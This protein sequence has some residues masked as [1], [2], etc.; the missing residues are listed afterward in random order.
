M[1]NHS[2]RRLGFGLVA[3]IAVLAFVAI[4]MGSITMQIFMNRKTAVR[5]VNQV[6][7][8]WLARAGLEIAAAKVLAGADQYR[9]ESV[10]LIPTGKVS[11][12]VRQEKDIFR[13]RS[14]ASFQGES[15]FPVVQEASRAYRR[16]VEGERVRVEV[17][18][19]PP[20]PEHAEEK[21]AS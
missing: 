13:V 9:G 11:I 18:P 10:E 20:E 1:S 12:E 6:Q 4:L 15:P 2:W 14:E 17:L 5:R 8:L 3:L 19:P 21:E 7:A 16:I